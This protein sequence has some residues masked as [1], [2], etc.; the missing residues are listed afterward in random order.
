MD[1]NE[2]VTRFCE[3]FEK[4][5]LDE[6]LS[7]LSEDCRYHNIPMEPVEGKESIRKT[8]ESF[9]PLLG[10]LRF[11]TLHQV[12]SGNVV[13]N[14]R[15]DHFTPPGA[16]PFGLQVTGIF[17][18]TNGKISAWRDYFDLRQFETALADKA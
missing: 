16:K 4:G 10:T 18:V 15:V 17:E 1:A 5:D 8:L 2:I 3:S 13:M 6:T 7:Y 12:A 14:E 11:E 9:G